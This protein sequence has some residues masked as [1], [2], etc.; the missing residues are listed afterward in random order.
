MKTSKLNKLATKLVGTGKLDKALAKAK[1]YTAVDSA[2][3]ADD[4]LW[5]IVEKAGVA[6]ADFN[7][8]VWA[9]VNQASAGKTGLV[10]RKP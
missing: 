9:C 2:I 4:E 5:T 7:P 6:P 3:N 8:L 10:R 1:S